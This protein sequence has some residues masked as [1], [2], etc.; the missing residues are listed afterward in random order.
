MNRTVRRICFTINN[1]D[2]ETEERIKNFIIENCQYGIFGREICPTTGTK[3]L[4][5]F[6]N[7]KNP[8][9][10]NKVKSSLHNTAHLEKANGTDI[11]N[12]EYCSKS[13]DFFE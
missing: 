3:H 12:K 4:Q 1:Y 2:A 7:L 6:L 5:G 9:R 13:G 11:Q 10:F 8:T